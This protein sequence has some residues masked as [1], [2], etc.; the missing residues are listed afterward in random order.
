MPQ[1]GP[2]EILVIFV[3]ALLV[4]GP[5]EIPKVARQAAKAWREVQRFQ[6]NLRRDIDEVLREDDEDDKRSTTPML[7]PKAD[8]QPPSDATPPADPTP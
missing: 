2:L 8:A 4:F 7:P 6:A 1:V 5:K 3:V